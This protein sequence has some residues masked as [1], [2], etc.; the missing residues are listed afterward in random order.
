M[1]NSC[2]C[3]A[4]PDEDILGPGELNGLSGASG[5]LVTVPGVDI[6]LAGL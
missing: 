5:L 6:P 2:Q 4:F 3:L 1:G